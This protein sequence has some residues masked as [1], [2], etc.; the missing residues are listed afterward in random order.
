MTRFESPVTIVYIMSS[1]RSGSTILDIVLGNHPEIESTG[2]VGLLTRTTW[3][4]QESIRGIEAKRTRLPICACGKRLDVHAVDTAAVEACPFWASVRREWIERAGRDAVESYPTLQDA[5]DRYRR[6]P[7]LLYERHRPSP[8]FLSYARLTRTLFESMRAVSGKP[9][10]VDSSKPPFRALAFAIMPGIDLRLVHLVRDPRAVSASRKKVLRKDVQAGI[11]WDHTPASIWRAG[12]TWTGINLLSEWVCAQLRPDRAIRLR[13]EDFLDDIESALNRIGTLV[14][15]DFTD[16]ANAASSGDPMQV[17]HN[18]GGNRVRMSGSVT[19]QPDTVELENA[20]S[21]KD[22]QLLRLLT[23][24]VTRRY[25]YKSTP[26][27]R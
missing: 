20:L 17:G 1:G 6:W 24:S 16:V 3:I 22:Q 21:S 23:G 18:I 10:I 5:F 9:I 7:R 4:S 19:L 15:L 27:S 26:Y 11:E 8:R 14:G 12:I 25:G 2:E 13:H